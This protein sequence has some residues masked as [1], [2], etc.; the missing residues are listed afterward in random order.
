[1]AILTYN[2]IIPWGIKISIIPVDFRE[3]KLWTTNW[4][5]EEQDAM[6]S[7]AQ[8]NWL[9]LSWKGQDRKGKERKGNVEH[10][11]P[12]LLHRPFVTYIYRHMV[13]VDGEQWARVNWRASL[14][15]APEL[16]QCSIRTIV[17]RIHTTSSYSVIDEFINENGMEWTMAR[18][19]QQ[20]EIFTFAPGYSR[21][22]GL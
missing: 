11:F 3:D 13:G 16:A 1:M 4:L 8:L 18:Q 9:D 10:T 7:M 5:G 6:K 20:G 14:L 17:N 21:L 12:Y 15:R 22:S 2:S 19:K